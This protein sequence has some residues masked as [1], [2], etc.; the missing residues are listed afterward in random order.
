MTDKLKPITV[1]GASAGTGKTYRLASEFAASLNADPDLCP[2]QIIATTFTNKAADELT[3]RLRTFLLRGNHWGHAQALFAAMIGT[4]NSVCGRLVGNLAI[5]AGLSPS[6]KIIAEEQQKQVFQEA[7]EQVTSA[8]GSDLWPVIFRLGRDDDWR[9]DIARIAD[10]A[11]QN[12]ISPEMLTSFAASSWESLN[13]HLPPS[14]EEELDF[15]A[16][17]KREISRALANLPCE[18]DETKTTA[19]QKK[20]LSDIEHAWNSLGEL[21]WHTVVKLS[22]LK[23]GKRSEVVVQRLNELARN[24]IRISAFRQDIRTFIEAAFSCAADCLKAYEDFKAE[25]G[26]LDFIDQERLALALLRR[27]EIREALEGKFNILFVD[28]FQD[29]SPIQLAVFLELARIVRSSIWVGDEKQSIFGFRGA[30][31]ILMQDA[32]AK[33]VPDT[34]G[35]RA[36]LRKSYRSRPVLVDFV[37]EVFIEALAPLGINPDSIKIGETSRAEDK[38]MNQALHVWWVAGSNQPTATESLAHGVLDILLH[39]EVWLVSASGDTQL[40]PIKGSDIVILCRSN[41]HRIQIADA[42]AKIGIIVSTERTGLLQSHESVL[43]VAVLR[44]LADRY[45]TLAMAEIVRYTDTNEDKQLWLR[46]WL[47]VGYDD[48]QSRYPVLCELDELRKELVGLTPMECM[49]LATTAPSVLETI[50]KWGNQ[51]QRLLNLEALVGLA[52]QYEEFCASDHSAATVAGLVTF[53]ESDCEDAEQ[54][55]NPDEHAVH[56]LTYH[57]SKGLEWPMVIMFDLDSPPPATAFGIHVP[58]PPSEFD[59]H[60]PLAQRAIRYWPWP[61][62]QQRTGLELLDYTSQTLE[63]SEASLQRDA[64]NLRLLYVGMTRPR[65][66]LV[67]ACRNARNGA[68]WLMMARDSLGQSIFQLDESNLGMH[69]ILKG[70]SQQIALHTTVSAPS[71]PSSSTLDFGQQR[72][73]SGIPSSITLTNMPYS[74]VASG[75]KL[76]ADESEQSIIV[77]RKINLGARLVLK[78]EADMRKLG[79]AL[80]LFLA[81]DDPSLPMSDRLET[82]KNIA[83]SFLVSALPPED[84]VEASTRLRN[85]LDELYSDAVWLTE[86]PVSGRYGTQRIQGA[87]DLLL[88]M[89]EGYVVVDH[90]SFPGGTDSWETRAISHY[91]QLDAYAALV[92]QATSKPVIAKL[93]HMP[94]LGLLIS[95]TATASWSSQQLPHAEEE[96]WLVF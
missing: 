72:Y 64:E 30:D 9:D 89:S 67:L 75:L 93:V 34:G 4:V 8:Y 61:Y 81:I 43:C 38:R 63:M 73:I 96:S 69:P 68:E 53:L 83:N 36:N 94:L 80:H 7:V 16:E 79:D 47:E 56:V 66:Y 82:A 12:D 88:E 22:K 23:P 84:F 70:P 21:P 76:S 57:K 28:E 19:D 55:A 3:H 41:E 2:T 18:G 71:I 20:A 33:L 74:C 62:R 32:V 86:W 49:Q 92:E 50:L 27:P 46:D 25:R 51:R 90:K 39:P 31:P 77:E 10:I 13:A 48:V 78:G 29:T 85:N 26:L 95:L 14:G 60:N 11:R 40:R 35:S 54:P 5:D 45:D 65:D 1:I 91:P 59:A 6:V 15:H 52:N 44:Y 17:L 87:I 58:R 24:H 37:N 42:L